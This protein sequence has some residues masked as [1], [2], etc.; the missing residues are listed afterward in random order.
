MFLLGRK[1]VKPNAI[2]TGW[3]FRTKPFIHST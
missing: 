3:P 2:T 1:K